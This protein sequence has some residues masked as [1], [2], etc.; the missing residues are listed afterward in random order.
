M[1][2]EMSGALNLILPIDVT[3]AGGGSSKSLCPDS[4]GKPSS[5]HSSLLPARSAVEKWETNSSTSHH[6]PSQ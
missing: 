5:H 4:D 1:G 6:S 3:D 2:L